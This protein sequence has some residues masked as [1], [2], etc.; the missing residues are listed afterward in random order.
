MKSKLNIGLIGYGY[1]GTNLLR[2]IVQ[3]ALSGKIVVCD[4]N[5]ERLK[6]VQSIFINLETTS[7]PADIFQNPEIDAVVIA[8]PTSSHYILANE[9]LINGKHV[10]AEKPLSTSVKEVEE[11]ISTAAANN[12]ILMVDHIYLYNPVIHQLKK[13][14]SEEFLGRINYIDATRINLGIYQDDIN[15]LWDLA[16]HDISI[17]NYLIDEKPKSARAIGKLNLN[18]KVEDLAYLFLEY[19]SGLLIQIN[20]SWASPVKIRKMIIGGEKK[21]I[22]YDDIESTNKLIIYDYMSKQT[23]DEN[24]SKLIDYRLGDITIPKY[25]ITEPLSNVIA[26][27]Y[28]CILTGR[29]PLSDGINALDVVRILEKAEQSLKSNG[30]IITIA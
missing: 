17:I 26:E 27:F 4:T 9:A 16:C 25:E 8:T 12:L 24:K 7:D 20:G 2:N 5:S 1:W 18:N 23:A 19:E 21:M 14:I 6:T 30:I 28:D 29:K 15:V 3:Q 10:L 11:L 13:Y 22:I